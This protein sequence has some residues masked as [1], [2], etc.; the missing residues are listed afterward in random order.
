MNNYV[1]YQSSSTHYSK[2]IS[3]VKVLKKWVKVKVSVKNNG[4][5]NEYSC[6]NSKL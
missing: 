2:V 4:K 5:H 3:N 1:K 6:E